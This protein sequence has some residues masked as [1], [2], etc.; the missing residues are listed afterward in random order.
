MVEKR[1][2]NEKLRGKSIDVDFLTKEYDSLVSIYIHHETAIST[3]FNFYL[4]ILTAII[5]A[6]VLLMQIAGIDETKFLIAVTLLTFSL[7]LGY[8]FLNAILNISADLA[9]TIHSIN[10][11]KNSMFAKSNEDAKKINYLFNPFVRAVM[12][13]KSKSMLW[14]IKQHLFLAM[15]ADTHLRFIGIFNDLAIGCLTFLVISQFLILFWWQTL[16]ISIGITGVAYLF[17]AEY[18]FRELRR[19][20]II[21][22]LRVSDY[23]EIPD[24]WISE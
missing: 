15:N 1:K 12:P 2:V 6:I 14:S 21:R 16:L 13:N 19:R 4:T 23:K 10:S 24:T 9:H 18:V 7:I 11:L 5:G 8:A 3:I 22:Q 17:Q 20:I